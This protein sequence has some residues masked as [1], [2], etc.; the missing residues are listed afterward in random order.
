ML[1]RT[2]DFLFFT[3]PRDLVRTPSYP[4]FLF[5]Q[6]WRGEVLNA[7]T[8]IKKMRGLL[9]EALL[10]QGTPNDNNWEHITKQIGM[11]SY[12]GLSKEQS[13]AMVSKHHIY[14]LDTGRI[15]VAGLNENSI[16]I[17]AE[18]IHDVVTTLPKSV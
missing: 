17:A 14:M 11:F 12:T 15:N 6:E 7:M 1:F 3:T 9:R 10:N 16:P 18:A 13:D 8:R 5:F 4:I 2:K